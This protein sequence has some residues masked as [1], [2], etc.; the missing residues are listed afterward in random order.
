[1]I[2]SSINV[3]NDI[4]KCDKK[5]DWFYFD[6]SQIF[7]LHKI[8]PFL[9]Q[10]AAEVLVQGLV[11]SKLDYGNVFYYG[12]PAALIHKLQRVQNA[13]ARLV[14]GIRKFDHITPILKSLHWLPVQQRIEY[15]VLL[16]CFQAIHGLA[17]D[18]LSSLLSQHVPI[19]CLQS[20]YQK[21][22]GVPRTKSKTYGDRALSSVA[23]LL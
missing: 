16:L 6:F 5:K 20:S 7:L 23:P 11:V 14:C 9:T 12:L 1:M 15:K 10:D 4:S 13:A 18:C 3:I 22:L 19:R 2:V 21:L 17:P 8:R